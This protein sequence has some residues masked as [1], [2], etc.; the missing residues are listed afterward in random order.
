MTRTE[1]LILSTIREAT[2]VIRV[3]AR[4]AP[5]LA[6]QTERA[7]HSV[8]LQYAEGTYARGANRDAKL[9]GAYA[10]AK[11]AMAA[12]R[13]AVACGA[14]SAEGAQRTLTGLDHVAAV[15]YLKRTRPR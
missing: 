15:L 3:M 5:D 13:V 11:E 4:R 10:E 1:D 6:K 8:A 7:L 2:P 9:Q 12:L 14:L